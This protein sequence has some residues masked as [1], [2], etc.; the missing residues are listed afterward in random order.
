MLQHINNTQSEMLELIVAHDSEYGIARNNKLPWNIRED[1]LFFK[2]KTI[3]NVVI[4]G[5][6]TFFSL[7]NARPL[8]KR[9]NI[10]ITSTPE[11][12][13][14]IMNLYPN[15]IF[16]S[17]EDIPTKLQREKAYFSQKYKITPDFSVF[18]IGGSMVYQKYLPLCDVLW[19]TK[20]NKNYNCDLFFTM[21]LNLREN[22][23]SSEVV[24]T[25]P[26]FTIT[27]FQKI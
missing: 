2:E 18:L 1:M 9:L 21:K 5:K 7:P 19:I 15:I 25:H 10:V 11:K 4:M 6:N 14:H 3:N 23:Y 12:Y 24:M 16:T 8:S 27:K 17:D 22:E 13:K 20:I 26:E